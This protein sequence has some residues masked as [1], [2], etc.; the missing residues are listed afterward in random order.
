[1]KI[2][3]SFFIFFSALAQAEIHRDKFVGSIGYFSVAA[4]TDT[5]SASIA[6]LGCFSF[7]YQKALA[8]KF[9]VAAG[10]T[11]LAPEYSGGDLGYGFSASLLYY[12]VG[13]NIEEI[14]NHNGI[15]VHTYQNWKPYVGAGFYQRNFQSIKSSY[16]GPG[17]V[18]GM[19]RYINQT[20]DLKL[21]A[22]YLTLTGEES[23]TATETNLLVGI[24]FK[25]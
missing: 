8:H 5:E 6:N 23:Q 2:L 3:L 22:R 9:D 12:P 4:K 20:M 24:V 1:M 11:I 14:S 25:F 16:A 19:D 13:G 18:F 10:Y 21:E 7:G 17:V 15:Q